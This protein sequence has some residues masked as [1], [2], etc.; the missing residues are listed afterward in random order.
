MR[1]RSMG[2]VKGESPACVRKVCVS[3]A[4]M[5]QLL[6]YREDAAAATARH[7]MR[8]RLADAT[9]CFAATQAAHDEPLSDGTLLI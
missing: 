7:R 4:V 2:I 1:I 3:C 6:T 5:C 8:G 9:R